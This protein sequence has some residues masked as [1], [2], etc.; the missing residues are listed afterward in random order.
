[1]ANSY[2]F[3]GNISAIKATTL[4]VTTNKVVE[5]AKV[6]VKMGSFLVPVNVVWDTNKK[7]ATLTKTFGKLLAGDYT[8][9]VTT[10]KET[11]KNT[12]KV[13][14][15]KIEK[16]E[17][18]STTLIKT[19]EAG[20]ATVAYKVT[21]QYGEDITE[22]A[23]ISGVSSIGTVAAVKGVATVTKGSAWVDTDKT[24]NVTLYNGTKNVSAALTLSDASAIDAITL[25][26]IV[27]PK[28]TTRLSGTVANVKVD[29][30]AV[31]QYG[32]EVV[33]ND[34]TGITPVYG[35]S[36]SNAKIQTID[37]K[38]VLTVDVAAVATETS[39]YL[40]LI[41]NKNGRAASTSFTLY[42]VSDVS[43]F[44]LSPDAKVIKAGTAYK[45]WIDAV[46]TYGEQI[47]ADVLATKDA[48]FSV[49]TL[50]PSVAAVAVGDEIKYDATAKK[51]YV[52]VNP[53]AAGKSTNLVVTLK[54]NA[55]SAS[56][57]ITVQAASQIISMSV[58]ANS[59]YFA[60][61]AKATL[62]ASFIDQYGEKVESL[63]GY[64]VKFTTSDATVL[65]AIANK[66]VADMVAGVEVAP[67]TGQAGKSTKLT[68]QIVKD[69]T[70]EVVDSKDIAVN[71]I[72]N[73]TKLTYYVS[74]IAT[75]HG[76]ASADPTSAY[77]ANIELT[78]KDANG[79]IV[80]LPATVIKSV[81]STNTALVDVQKSG[82]D[83]VLSG[84][85]AGIKEGTEAT[86]TITVVAENYDG[87]V[88]IVKKDVKV[89]N[90]P[91]A[92]Q[93]L[94]ALAADGETEITEVELTAASVAT[95]LKVSAAN[96][97]TSFMFE[98]KDQFGVKIEAGTYVVTNNTTG[99][100]ITIDA[101]GAVTVS[102][103]VAASKSFNITAITANGLTKTITVKTK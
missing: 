37:G 62:K 66:T 43:D 10:E 90:A 28:D 100:T 72:S 33:L 35:N 22:T 63:A 102:G 92:A 20:K 103:T 31:D 89:S 75:L 5:N 11:A 38:K 30:T 96:A 49:V 26:S 56:L 44:S 23:A 7:E 83:Y 59:L 6:E 39:T 17:I 87:S 2:I 101:T 71:V 24:V 55:K 74:D 12:A 48:N 45:V 94:K 69:A 61:G 79:N 47:K 18:A 80:Y 40:N 77:A 27:L 50:D 58:S 95:G 51:A 19:A 81:T 36:V 52:D 29:Y 86:A 67:L 46:D 41:V 68:V 98:A 78:A 60:D 73:D 4:K 99:A 54:K 65:A 93:S 14:A 25:G 85:T 53:V 8:V 91:I 34:L 84:L 70:S 97:P 32:N 3:I 64:T 9:T 82:N 16:I 21:N 15:E 42:P 88:A 76:L 13:E 1:M 57:P